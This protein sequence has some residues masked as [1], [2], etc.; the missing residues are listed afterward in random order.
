MYCEHEDQIQELSIFHF[1]KLFVVNVT[2]TLTLDITR[3]RFLE[4]ALVS[5][6][7]I[8]FVIDS[9]I[10]VLDRIYIFTKVCFFQLLVGDSVHVKVTPTMT[11]DLKINRGRIP[12][13]TNLHTK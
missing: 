2:V 6:G 5:V 12:V 11:F 8:F 7:G 9:L 4:I 10:V 1:R 13:K 3:N